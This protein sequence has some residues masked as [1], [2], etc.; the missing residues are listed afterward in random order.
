MDEISAQD[1]LSGRCTST[2]GPR[3]FVA[4]RGRR[5]VRTVL[6]VDVGA[7]RHLARDGLEDESLLP[8]RRERELDLSIQSSRPQ[9]RGVLHHTR[10]Y[11]LT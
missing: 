7:H 5:W 10:Q 8:P 11:H 6:E 9:Q 2:H 1:N 3:Q 4:R